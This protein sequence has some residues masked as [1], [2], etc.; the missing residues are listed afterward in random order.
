MQL[1]NGESVLTLAPDIVRASG[2]EIAP[3][4][5]Q[6]TGVART[7][8]ASIIDLQPFFDLAQRLAAAQAER[9][10]V[11]GQA[12]TS[13]A[14]YERVQAL[15]RDDRNMSEKSV[16]EA[17]TLALSDQARMRA[18]DI[19]RGA[20]LASLR[21]QFGDVLAQAAAQPATALFRQLSSSKAVVARV[22]SA[23]MDNVPF[24]ERIALDTPE[25]RRVAARQ[26]SPSP[27]ADPALQGVSYLYLVERSIPTGTRTFAHVA[28]AASGPAVAGVAIPG[29]AIVWYGGQRWSYVR[30][31]PDR[32][33]RRPV[34]ATDEYPDG[35][36]VTKGFHAGEAVVI[37]GAQLLLSEEQR[38]QGIATQCKD[39][40]ECDD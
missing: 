3:L 40:P 14:Q 22:T 29:N 26:L 23:T 6:V 28:A 17:Q 13:Q 37:R 8:Y 30:T 9:E 27:Q 11:S 20:L 7:A 5:A 1:I 15:Y 36:V 18:N 32:Y 24:P 39:P 4:A 34:S 19:T 10:I 25:G 35:V 38:P 21:Q 31:A 12:R 33:T 16:Q 2:I